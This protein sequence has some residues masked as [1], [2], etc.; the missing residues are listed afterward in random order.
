MEKIID[1]DKLGRIILRRNPRAKHYLLRIRDGQV[2]GTMPQH[3]NEREMLAFIE[4][5]RERLVRMLHHSPKR[6]RWDEST[7]LQ[8]HT[9][10]VH[11]FRTPRSNFYMNLTD[12]VLHIACPE[13]TDFDSEPIQQFLQSLFETALRREALRTLPARLHM[14]AARHA[15]HYTGVTIRNNRS[16]WGSCTSK[17]HINLSLSLMLL[18]GHLIDYVLLHEL[19]HTVEMNHGERF[20]QLMNKVTGGQAQALR[21]ELR[22]THHRHG[23]P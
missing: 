2:W 8:T 22:M 13:D 9:F 4:K 20:R 23:Q 15:F 17:K 6:R 7:N 5:Q 16:K 19:C 3:G 11:I 12:G 18:S 21:D 14:L 1:D 10:R